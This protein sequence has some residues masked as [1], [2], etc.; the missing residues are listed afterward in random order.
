VP[1]RAYRH[2]Q[3]NRN[4][5]KQYQS[6]FVIAI[7]VE[8]GSFA[9]KLAQLDRRLIGGVVVTSEA[10]IR[11]TRVMMNRKTILYDR[12]RSAEWQRTWKSF[13]RETN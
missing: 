3:T 4:F 8:T 10:T 2:L 11:S 1:I 5:F 9:Q 6:E 12:I 13:Y 7:R